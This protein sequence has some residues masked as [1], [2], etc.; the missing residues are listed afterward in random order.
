MAHLGRLR[1]EY[2]ELDGLVAT[3]P[4]FLE[5]IVGATAEM[6]NAKQKFKLGHKKLLEGRWLEPTVL[7]LENGEN[8]GRFI[9]LVLEMESRRCGFGA[10]SY[11]IAHG[12]G[13][14]TA[15]E[16]RRISQ[17][18]R[19]VAC[20]CDRDDI[21]PNGQKSATF[22]AA[23]RMFERTSLI[24]FFAGTPGREAENFLPFSILLELYPGYCADSADYLDEILT[25][26]G[27]ADPGDC[28]WQ[29]LDLKEGM[30][31][32]LLAKACNDPEKILWA[33]EKFLAD[34]AELESLEI[35]GFGQGIITLFMD[36]GPARAQFHRFSRSDYWHYHFSNWIARLLW[37]AAG[38]KPIRYL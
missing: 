11:E 17:Y 27:Q 14:T 10:T 35:A 29:Y 30:R 28:F 25:A 21:I 4:F 7:L 2:S 6:D 12:G 33:S 13:T 23:A 36:N 34:P 22:N 8:D 1:E 19:I 3:A 20:V 9:S 32:P 16:L 18:H 26:Q 5:I 38:R 24:G 15:S 31:G 37:L